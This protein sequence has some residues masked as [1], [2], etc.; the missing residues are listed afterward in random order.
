M[1]KIRLIASAILELDVEAAAFLPKRVVPGPVHRER[2]N[3]RI[4]AEDRRRSVALM[5][6]AVDDGN[7]AAA[8]VALQHT[9]GY[10]HIIEDAIPLAPVGKGVMGAAGEVGG[11]SVRQRGMCGGHGG[12]NR[13]AR[14][15]HHLRR[16]G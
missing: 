12:A 10:G 1:R 11:T 2:E 7:P 16:P 5:D 6:I 3:L 13:S 8:E 9:G 15:L 14:A 4:A